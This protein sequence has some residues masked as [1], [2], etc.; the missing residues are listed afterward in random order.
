MSS[1]SGKESLLASLDKLKAAVGNGDCEEVPAIMQQIL[2]E[3]PSIADGKSILEP[4]IKPFYDLM[5]LEQPPEG[6]MGAFSEDKKYAK[7]CEDFINLRAFLLSLANGDLS[8]KLQMKGYLAGVLKAF[9]AN[10]KHMIWQTKMIAEG[11][12]SRR[13]HFLGEFSTS[14]NSMVEQLNQARKKLQESE[15]RFRSLAVT[16]A[17]SSLPNRRH[18]FQLAKAEFSRAKRYNTVLSIIMLDIDYFK[19]INDTYGH[20]TGDM[21]IRVVAEQMRKAIR[22]SDT[23]C[24]YGGEEFIVLLPQTELAEAEPVARRIKDYIQ[25][26]NVHFDGKEVQVTASLGVSCSGG[27]G[28]PDADT[29]GETL[30]DVLKRADKAL[31]V[32]KESGRNR[33][34][35]ADPEIG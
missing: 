32:A 11:D 16:D 10:L 31:Y 29:Q 33:V 9:Q 1:G 19:A 3:C 5:Q 26:Q 28:R 4:I 2:A 22:E 6:F 13:V 24:R 27:A 30:D 18:F 34:V 20:A 21:V 8:Q 15:K 17:L 23:P 7:L 25:N 14:F 12:F 35:I